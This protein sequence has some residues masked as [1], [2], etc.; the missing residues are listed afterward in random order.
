GPGYRSALQARI[1][2]SGAPAASD[3]SVLARVAMLPIEQ[4]GLP[5]EA[6]RAEISCRASRP[7]QVLHQVVGEPEPQRAD[8]AGGVVAGV[9]REPARAADE[10]VLRVPA[11]QM[12]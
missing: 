3:S 12:R 1:R 7:L 6:K 10:D 11:L 4:Q 2:R 5:D 8:R 9:L